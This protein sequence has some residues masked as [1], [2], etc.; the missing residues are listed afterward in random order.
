MEKTIVIDGKNIRLSV[1]GA[2]PIL[3]QMQFGKDYMKEILKLGLNSG[4]DPNNP[5]TSNVDIHNLGIDYMFFYEVIWCMAKLTDQSIPDM[6]TWFASFDSFPIADVIP[7]VEDMMVAN[8]QT[9][10]KL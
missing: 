2:L 5:D 4:I 7:E 3:Y 1:N 10:K 6:M 9:K 8:I